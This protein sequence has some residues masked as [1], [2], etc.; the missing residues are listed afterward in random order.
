MHS[1]KIFYIEVKRSEKSYKYHSLVFY[2][3]NFC[4]RKRIG[5]C[6][7]LIFAYLRKKLI[8]AKLQTVL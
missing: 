8:I 6:Q 5:I 1:T 2:T 7:T 3:D 4:K